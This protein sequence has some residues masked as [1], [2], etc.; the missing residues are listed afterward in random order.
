MNFTKFFDTQKKLNENLAIDESLS[1]YKVF[2]RKHVELYV[3]ISELAKITQCYNYRVNTEI[4]FD[5]QLTLKTYITCLREIISLSLDN[6][7]YDLSDI[8][9]EESED[10]LSDQFLNLYIDVN[11]II[12]SPSKDHF[13]TIL[14]DF[15]SLGLSLGLTESM[16]TNEFCN[17]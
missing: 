12:M 9:V 15:I 13:E 14:Q 10:C 16:I 2:A 6:E 1:Q 11:D 7:H 17:I 3:E 8:P 5:K 4:E